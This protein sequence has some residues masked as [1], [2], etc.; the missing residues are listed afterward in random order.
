MGVAVGGKDANA[1]GDALFAH[2]ARA[3]LDVILTF[4]TK[5]S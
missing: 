5:G 3:S 2:P 1:E 4:T